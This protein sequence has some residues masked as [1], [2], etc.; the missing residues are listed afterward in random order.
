MNKLTLTGWLLT[1]VAMVSGLWLLIDREAARKSRSAGEIAATVIRAGD[2]AKVDEPKAGGTMIRPEFLPQGFVIVVKDKTG[3]SNKDSP[4]H[5]ASSWN[6]WDPGDATQ[7]LD[8]RSDLRWQIVI[9]KGRPD[10]PLA[11][12]FTR[13]SWDLEEVDEKLE[14]IANR[15]LPLVDTSKLKEGERPV[16]EFEVVAW[17]DQRP[18]SGARPDL[19]PYHTLKV[20]GNV[21]RLQVPGGA[22][23]MAVATRDVLVY[24]PPGYDDPKNAGVKY[25]VLYMQDGQNLFEKLPG[26]PAEWGADETAEALITAG[27]VQP[28]IIVAIPHAGGQRAAEYLPLDLVQGVKP[29]GD[30]YVQWLASEVMPRVEHAFRVKTGP[31]NTAIGG[32]SLG[33]VISLHAAA[34]RPDLFGAVLLESLSGLGEKQQAIAYAKAIKKWPSKVYFGFGSQEAGTGAGEKA[35]NEKYLAGAKDFEKLLRAQSGVQV[36]VVVQDTVHNEEAWAKRFG[37]ALEFLYPVK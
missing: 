32:A 2:A 20:T 3:R 5:L 18:N 19:D 10:T 30:Q 23:P 24:L 27:K 9:P 11:F 26:I 31:E 13:G 29:H 34:T 37:P 21:K 33:A 14:S 36:D 35:L 15:S 22:V 25:P 4:I 6:G 7:I 28:L 1:P 16:L 17:G 12:K 8:A